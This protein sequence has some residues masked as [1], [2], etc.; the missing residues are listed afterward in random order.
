MN[1]DRKK[2]PDEAGNNSSKN[3]PVGEPNPSGERKQAQGE[4][5]KGKQFE[6]GREGSSGK[7]RADQS[8]DKRATNVSGDDAN[9][10]EKE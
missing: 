1:N 4:P 10:D 5:S 9:T 6:G 8:K 2:D 3:T 7:R